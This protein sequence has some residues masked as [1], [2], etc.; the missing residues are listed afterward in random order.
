MFLELFEIREEDNN[1]LA[2]ENENDQQQS[3]GVGI[4]IYLYRLYLFEVDI[5]YIQ[6][7]KRGQFRVITGKNRLMGEHADINL[8][9]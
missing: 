3:W 9:R 8:E 6:F 7:L 2:F 1:I 5:H 4:D